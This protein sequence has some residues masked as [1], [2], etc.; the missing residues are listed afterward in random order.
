MSFSDRIHTRV[1]S[2]ACVRLSEY[3]DLSFININSPQNWNYHNKDFLTPSVTKRISHQPN[4]G[5]RKENA[6]NVFTYKTNSCSYRNAKY[7]RLRFNKDWPIVDKL[8]VMVA[9]RVHYFH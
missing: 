7:E 4:T 9:L 1:N 6:R 5:L 2:E 3:R 8:T